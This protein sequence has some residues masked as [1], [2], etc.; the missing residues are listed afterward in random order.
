[1]IATFFVITAA[2]LVYSQTVAF[3]WDEG[4]HLLA[5]QLIR[6]GR[7]PYAD[8]LFA[9]TPLNTYW[10]A[11]LIAMFGASWRPPHAV[12]AVETAG[13]TVLTSLYVLR[14][15]PVPEWR[16]ILAIA[17]AVLTG[18]NILVFQFGTIAQAYGLCLLLVVAAFRLA[19]AAAERQSLAL[20]VLAGLGAG[21]AAAASLLTAATGPVLLVWL[22]LRA[23]SGR[24][25]A[26]A[27]GFAGGALAGL[28]PVL[29]F[30][31]RW[32]RQLIFDVIGYHVFYRQVKWEGWLPHDALLLTDWL[33]S[34]QTF[35]MLGLAIAGLIF[36]RRSDWD[37]SVRAEFYLCG[38][39]TVATGLFV[40]TA[41][42][43]FRQYFVFAVPFVAIMAVAGWYAIAH[44]WNRVWTSALVMAI[45]AGGLGR[46][47]YDESDNMTWA[48]F[49]EV[50]RDVNAVTPKGATLAA[51]E[52]IYFLTG[53][54]P[55]AGLEWTSG[56]K[57]E[58]PLERAR[59]LHVLPQSELDREVK[60]G[61]FSTY[62]TCYDGEVDRIGLKKIYAQEKETDDCYVFWDRRH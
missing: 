13:A 49:D 23:R 16:F 11:L 32:P 40:A 8:F 14:R 57:I 56:H 53:R 21:A 46:N 15:F 30:L 35:I 7:R 10:N 26:T 62:E 59:P 22:T 33:D 58:I 2:L 20:T 25:I 41:H 47:L 51:D 54:T 36:L 24:R 9:Q 43:T 45:L 52:Q 17:T 37:R 39:L 4:F 6:S 42:P 60:Q 27:A 44:R 1:L 5:A 29:P 18:L 19:V 48:S 61:A 55:P 12:A 34:S 31:L 28:G 38:W 3:A 50:V